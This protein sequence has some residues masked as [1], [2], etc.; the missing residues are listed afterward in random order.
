MV[1][2]Q[3]KFD[4]NM[5]KSSKVVGTIVLVLVAFMLAMAVVGIPL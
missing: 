4:D 5:G 2:C 3:M 1:R